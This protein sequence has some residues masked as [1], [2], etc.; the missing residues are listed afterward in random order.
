MK[1]DKIITKFEKKGYKITKIISN[2]N[3]VVTCPVGFVNTFTSYLAAYN[4]YFN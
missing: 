3:V 2:G 1:I 4:A